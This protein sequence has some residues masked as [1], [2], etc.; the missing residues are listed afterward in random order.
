M[1]QIRKGT[2]ET[3]SSST[4]TLNVVKDKS[5]E[6]VIEGIISKNVENSGDNRIYSPEDFIYDKNL[7][8]KGIDS[9][10][11]DESKNV[12][13]IIKNWYSKIQFI[14]SCLVESIRNNYP[15]YE[16]ELRKLIKKYNCEND[17]YKF[18]YNVSK[19]EVIELDE[20]IHG[21]EPFEIFKQKCISLYNNIGI[22]V[23]NVFIDFDNLGSIYAENGHNLLDDINYKISNFD[24]DDFSKYL[25][26][27]FD[28]NFYLIDSDEAYSPYYGFKIEII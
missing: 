19:K 11:G 20:R 5:I 16:R 8:I 15:E 23:E 21:Y 27:L 17:W 4:H 22:V 9:A 24:K 6:S 18:W 25:D 12:Y 1:K 13:H 7:M 14:G 3:N 2:F 28:D 26:E 10:D